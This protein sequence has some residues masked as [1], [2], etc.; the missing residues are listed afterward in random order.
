MRLIMPE[1]TTPLA[2]IERLLFGGRAAVLS[3]PVNTNYAILEAPKLPLEI[4]FPQSFPRVYSVCGVAKSGAHAHKEKTESEIMFV[5]TGEADIYLWDEN[6]NQEIVRLSRAQTMGCGFH[7]A[8][9]IKAGVWHT[10]RYRT[11]TLTVLN[12]A[13]SCIY[14]RGYYVEKPEDY[15]TPAGLERYRAE[16]AQLP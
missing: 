4:G 1:Q 14:D 3:L 12:V 6:G 8:V 5:V 13:A 7:L 16:F 11:N 10:V 15:F 9:F 2:R